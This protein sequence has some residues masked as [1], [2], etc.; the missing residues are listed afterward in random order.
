MLLGKDNSG[1]TRS[2]DVRK[3]HRPKRLKKREKDEVKIKSFSPE[4]HKYLYRP[5]IE[6]RTKNISKFVEK[7][8]NL[9][10]NSLYF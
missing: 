1:I 6:R 10:Q 3:I 7:I 5:K 9:P 4:I 2:R 8:G